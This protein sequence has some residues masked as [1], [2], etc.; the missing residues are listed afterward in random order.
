MTK[1]CSHCGYA[2]NENDEV[3]VNCNEKLTVCLISD[4][5]CSKD[6]QQSE[7]MSFFASKGIESAGQT[8]QREESKAPNDMQKVLNTQ[9][10]EKKEMGVVEYLVDML[11]YSIPVAGFVLAIIFA[12]FSKEKAQK[13]N[14]AK[15]VFVWKCICTGFWF[16]LLFVFIIVATVM[17]MLY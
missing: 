12:F 15:A 2:N 10:A 16:V 11:L 14:F 7:N 8:I 6:K 4:Q 17:S 1:L 5:E 13:K 3:C 9:S